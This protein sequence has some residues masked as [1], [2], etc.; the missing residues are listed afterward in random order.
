MASWCAPPRIRVRIVLHELNCGL[1]AQG[2]AVSIEE[3]WDA[4][5]VA[6]MGLTRATPAGPLITFAGISAL[7]PRLPR[8][9]RLPR[10]ATWPHSRTVAAAAAAARAVEAATQWLLSRA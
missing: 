10:P 2:G 6:L 3:S 1:G 7:T 4:A 5:A 9:P 8:L